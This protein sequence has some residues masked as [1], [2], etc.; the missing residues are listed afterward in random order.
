MAMQQ[1]EVP[2]L[3]CGSVVKSDFSGDAYVVVGYDS[4]G[5][6]ILVRQLIMN[7]PSEWTLIKN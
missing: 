4:S 3:K 7:H 2:K 5:T 6:P 1:K